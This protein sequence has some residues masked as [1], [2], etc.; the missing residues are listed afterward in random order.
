MAI[1]I[2][3]IMVMVVKM[4]STNPDLVSDD[5]YQKEIDYEQEIVAVK[6]MYRLKAETKI[7][8]SDEFLIFNLPLGVKTS[9]VTIE[10]IRP[11]DQNLD[12]TFVVTDTKTYMIPISKLQKG[13]YTVEM[14]FKV[15]GVFCMQKEK[16]DI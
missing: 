8:V 2:T 7:D 6:N 3:F 16:I 4:I 5:Y 11:N 1:F 12:K 14:S 10:L 9:D 15:D 13:K